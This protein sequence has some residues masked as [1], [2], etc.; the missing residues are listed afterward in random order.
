MPSVAS[1]LSA[2]DVANAENRSAAGRHAMQQQVSHAGYTP[3]AIVSN[4]P[5]RD[6]NIVLRDAFA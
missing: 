2:V 6:A 1:V 3:L 5:D 4:G